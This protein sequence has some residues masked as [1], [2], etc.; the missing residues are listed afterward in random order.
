VMDRDFD[1]LDGIYLVQ[2]SLQLDMHNNF[3]FTGLTYSILERSLV[4]TWRRASGDWVPSDSPAAVTVTFSEVSEFRFLP[5]DS[6][7][8]FSED[9]CTSGFGYW[10]DE[11]WAEDG[12]FQFV[13]EPGQTA[14]PSWLTAIA[15]ES[16]AVIAVRSVSAKALVSRS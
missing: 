7:L 1:I 6:G 14:D 13:E 12:F 4:L 3:S 9:D 10:T 2:S 16:G 11:D 8:P 5:R 15:F